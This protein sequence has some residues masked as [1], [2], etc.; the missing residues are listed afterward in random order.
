MK[1]G[2][3]EKI[4]DSISKQELENKN[5]KKIRNIDESELA[6]VISIS[7]QKIIR[8]TLS[9]ITNASEKL[10]FIQKLNNTIGIEDFEYENE[11]FKELLAVHN[12]ES[13]YSILNKYRPRTS[14]STSTLFTGNSRVTLESELSREIRTANEVDFLVSFIKF[15][16]LRLIYEDLVEFTKE[17]KLRV[18]TTSYMGASDYKAILDLAKL[19]NTEVK[20]SYD[21][22]GGT[23]HNSDGCICVIKSRVS[24]TL[25]KYIS[26]I[27]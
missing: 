20:I 15:S 2:L 25:Y 23:C 10:E 27:A 24:G 21:S 18:I 13:G 11:R 12:D 17:N 6:R 3:Y 26:C 9:Q 19:P 22:N 8:E 5:Y 7:Y 16:G 1:D 4:L 14:I